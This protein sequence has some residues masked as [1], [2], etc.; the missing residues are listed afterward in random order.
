MISLLLCLMLQ[1]PT[2]LPVSTPKPIPIGTPIDEN[3]WP[4]VPEEPKPSRIPLPAPIG[5]SV[6]QTDGL[7]AT[8]NSER[9]QVAQASGATSA[10]AMPQIFTAVHSPSTFRSLGG[11]TIWWRL[12]VHGPAGETIGVREFT[13]LADA[14]VADR[15]RL[16]YADGR[17]LGRLGSQVFAQRH[18]M[19]RLGLAE[20]AAEELR[21]FGLH[22]RLPWAFADGQQFVELGSDRMTASGE[23]LLRVRLQ[24]RTAGET[25]GP[26]PTGAPPVDAF[27]L[28]VAANG[29]PPRELVHTLA[30]TGQRRRVLLEDW[31]EIASVLVPFQR[32][33]V[34]GAGRPTTTLEVLRFEPGAATADRDF[35]VQ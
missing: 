7:A 9:G 22:A 32:I 13:H 19:Q 35:R 16:R 29:G 21:L 34:D 5:E 10:S 25:V 20:Q 30:A 3:G 27:E 33:Y 18:G 11:V 15:D 28:W 31:R 17:V 26:S 6:P 1:D 12:T 23:E 8:T 24:A 2:P 14:S 4:I